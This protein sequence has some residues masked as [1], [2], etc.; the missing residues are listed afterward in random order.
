[1]IDDGKTVQPLESRIFRYKNP[2][3]RFFCPLCRTE[4][5]FTLKPRL[6]K[7]NFL[8]IFLTTLFLILFAY[9]VMG[10]RSLFIYFVVWSVFEVCLRTFFRKEIPCPHCGFDASWYKRD[11]KVARRLVKEFWEKKEKEQVDREGQEVS[12]QAAVFQQ[13]PGPEVLEVTQ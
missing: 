6:S 8:Q 11:V 5:A 12:S 1:M 7:M 2:S 9:P 10:I 4:R 3:T 13:E